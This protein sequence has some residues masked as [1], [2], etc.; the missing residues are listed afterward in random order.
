M[1]DNNILVSII[2][3]V[4]NGEDYLQQT[5]DSVYNQTYKFIEYIIID[6]GSTD[7]TIS[8]IKKNE[9][10]ITKWIS[11]K[12][13]GLYDAMN[14]GI[15]LANGTLIGTINSDDWY[16][17]DA[18]NYVVNSFKKKLDA[19][20]IHANRYDVYPDGRKRIYKFNPSNFKFMYFGMTYSHPTV[21]VHKKIYEKYKYNILLKSLSDYQF[22]L[23]VFL[24]FKEDFVFI[25]EPIVNFR[26]GGISGQLGFYGELKEG[27]KARRNAGMSILA[28]SFSVGLQ[29]L[30]RPLVK[31]HQFLKK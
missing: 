27:Y 13:N 16:E 24:K 22:I 29:C 20:L 11:E 25:P 14:K 18:V 1:I 17:K 10:K 4:Y 21:F 12:D 9:D 31:I 19:K 26:L 6:G 5:I 7:N 2:T 23:Q 30:L 28:S 3:V 8:I 15:A